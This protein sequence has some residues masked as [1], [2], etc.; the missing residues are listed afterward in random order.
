MKVPA[1]HGIGSRS[2]VALRRAGALPVQALVALLTALLVFEHGVLPHL[3]AARF[4]VAGGSDASVSTGARGP[5]S[6]ARREAAHHDRAGCALCQ[7]S[8]HPGASAPAAADVRPLVAAA[9]RHPN[10]PNAEPHAPERT[11]GAPRSP[12]PA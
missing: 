9:A 6:P 4:A 12:P 11:L 5:E 10:V 3:H 2:R 1:K 8:A 7:A